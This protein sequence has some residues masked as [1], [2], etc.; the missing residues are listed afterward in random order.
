MMVYAK[1]YAVKFDI[2]HNFVAKWEN[3]LLQNISD[4]VY[5]SG[6]LKHLLYIENF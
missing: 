3:Y 5:L 2:N 1:F 6:M 4:F